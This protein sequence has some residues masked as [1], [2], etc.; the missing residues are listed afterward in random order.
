MWRSLVAHLLWERGA[1]TQM[2]YN[3]KMKT[4]GR[5]QI[6]KDFSNFRKSNR[7]DGYQH[8]CTD[9][10]REYDRNRYKTIDKSRKLNNRKKIKIRQRE[11]IN[12]AKSSGCVDCGITDIRVLDFDHVTQD[13]K[14]DISSAIS[15]GYSD[16]KIF[17][18]IA[19]CEVRCANCHRIVTHERKNK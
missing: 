16:Q 17:D 4:C 3:I 10:F 2:C 12:Q 9:C 15:R 13:K 14:F 19:K 18:E 1:A 8:W 7:Y 11:I 5:C 6:S